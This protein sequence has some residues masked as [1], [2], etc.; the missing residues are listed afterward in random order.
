ML[1]LVTQQKKLTLQ[2]QPQQQNSAD[3]VKRAIHCVKW[4]GLLEAKE[5]PTLEF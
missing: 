4:A 2:P 1:L 3:K 5:N